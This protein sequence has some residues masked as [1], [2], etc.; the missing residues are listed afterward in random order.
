MF[1]QG[2]YMLIQECVKE[3][4]QC[5]Y[6]KKTESKKIRRGFLN[7]FLPF[8]TVIFFVLSLISF[9]LNHLHNIYACYISIIKFVLPSKILIALLYE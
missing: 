6:S 2:K 8:L 3:L 5:S 1:G 9:A 4:Y 7:T